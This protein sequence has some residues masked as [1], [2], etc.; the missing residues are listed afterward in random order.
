MAGITPRAIA[1]PATA[2]A[3][4]QK[5]VSGAGQKWA[6]G[7]QNPRRDPFASAAAAVANWQQAV[8]SP[9][10][11]A[12]FVSGLSN[13]N[14]AAVVATVTGPGMTKYTSSATNKPAKA[15]AFFST[16]L[17]KL[18]NIVTQ[19]NNSNPKGPRGSAQNLTR[20]T[21]Y[22]QAVAATRGTN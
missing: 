6:T 20:L 10:A 19:L 12:A 14:Q 9:A 17:P 8:S 18:S 2:L 4:W 22:I 16:F 3:N 1:T 7:Y 11:A 5:G 13:V 15:Q 21:T